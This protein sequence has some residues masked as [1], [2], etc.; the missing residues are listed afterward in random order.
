[1]AMSGKVVSAQGR[2]APEGESWNMRTG[3]TSVGLHGLD[4]EIWQGRKR[5]ERLFLGQLVNQG[6]RASDERL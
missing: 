6:K 3:K 1:M 4:R 5:K 2:Q